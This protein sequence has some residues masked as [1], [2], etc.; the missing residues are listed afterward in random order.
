MLWQM[1]QDRLML[2]VNAFYTLRRRYRDVCCHPL[3]CSQL[4]KESVYQTLFICC[5]HPPPSIRPLLTDTDWVL[6]V[7]LY[8]RQHSSR[9]TTTPLCPLTAAS[10]PPSLALTPVLGWRWFFFFFG[11]RMFR[12]DGSEEERKKKKGAKTILERR[13]REKLLPKSVSI[14][15]CLGVFVCVAVSAV[16]LQVQSRCLSFFCS[17]PASI[18]R[19]LCALQLLRG[20]VLFSL[21][22]FFF[23]SCSFSSP[24]SPLVLRL[25]LSV[26][27]FIKP[28]N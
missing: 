16:V 23:S 10:L 17:S 25:C 15:I 3:L 1:S 20:F 6:L 21:F 4:G 7:K 8:A 11:P 13:G 5:Q 24:A 2:R 12:L 28:P 27:T 18:N 19:S 26:F 9:Q 22:F 14:C